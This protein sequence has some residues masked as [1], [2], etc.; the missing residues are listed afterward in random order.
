MRVA[1]HA[2]RGERA[3]MTAESCTRRTLAAVAIGTAICIAG[4][5]GSTKAAGSPTSVTAA[6][7]KFAAA[8]A[9]A[10]S[11]GCRTRGGTLTVLF[12]QD[13]DFVDPG[14]TFDIPS[15]AF[16][17][18]TT[19]RQLFQ[20]SPTDP[21]MLIPDI[22]SGPPVVTD[23]GRTITV[24]IKPDVRFSPPV[25][26][27]VTSADFRYAIER[28]FSKNV[29]NGYAPTDYA[30]LVGAQQFAAGKT[31]H[32]A[33]IVTPNSTTII[34]HLT[35][36]TA[37]SF[38]GAL[39]EPLDSPVPESYA[40]PFDTHNPSTYGMHE[41]ATGPYMIRNDA[42]GTLTGYKPNTIIQL[43]RNPNWNPKT[44][45]RPACLNAINIK[46]GY[47]DPTVATR[48]IVDGQSMV[49]GNFN[50]P[51]AALQPILTSSQAS[52]VKLV[53]AELD[54]YVAMNMA[55]PP[56]NNIDVRKAV[57]A[58]FD[59]RA[60]WLTQ[61]GEYGGEIASHFIPPGMP[62]YTQAGGA[63]GPGYDFISYPN[64]NL[65]LAHEYMRKAGY[66]SGVYHGPTLFMVGQNDPAGMAA[67]ETAEA[68][69]V[70]L[71]FKINLHLVT[72]NTLYNNY[73]NVPK[74]KVNICPVDWGPAY[75][76]G[77]S[78]LYATFDGTQILQ[79]GNSNYP[80]LNDPAINRAMVVAND[81]T[82]PALRA[83][84]WG[85]VDRMIV[86]QAPAVPWLWGINS[87]SE[88]ANVQGVVDPVYGL[89]DLAFASLR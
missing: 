55:L 25:D 35:T 5:G 50:A 75:N 46:E 30:V 6:K 4:C 32:I 16:L 8:N 14:V 23:G 2:P 84:R 18:Y 17:A 9:A 12:N 39:T 78:Q 87:D 64:G 57:L 61:G 10:A 65:T 1:L 62:G 26:R 29:A 86:A 51:A 45:F 74:V 73:C 59:R 22:A 3:Q 60:M 19:Q 85:Q 67:A 33:G 21:S 53:P 7:G 77:Q 66:T 34:F 69:F 48:E 88:S 52:Q 80:Q 58:V 38:L 70:K 63:N 41:V 81:T 82:N 68:Q 28:G 31:A 47:S 27:E 79:T 44:D 54:L 76:D 15:W 24:H 11:A 13:V 40:A 43:V 37:G 83:A 71:G 56:F 72:K 20:F 89:W 42:S 36:P 49:S